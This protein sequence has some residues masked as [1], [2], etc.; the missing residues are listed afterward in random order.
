M[1]ISIPILNFPKNALIWVFSYSRESVLY[2]FQ[3]ALASLLDQK[4]ENGPLDNI[5]KFRNNGC[6]KEVDQ[7]DQDCLKGDVQDG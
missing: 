2:L 6:L 5:M 4:Q 1:N 3:L 7:L